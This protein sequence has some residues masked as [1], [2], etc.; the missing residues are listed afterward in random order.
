MPAFLQFKPAEPM[1]Q[2]KCAKCQEEEEGQTVQHKCA[3]C[4]QAEE[5]QVQHKQP[6]ASAPG[7]IHTAAAGV[8]GACQPLPH[9]SRIQASFGHH[10][11]TGARAAVG[12]QAAQANARSGSLA[13]TIGDRIAFRRPPDV[14]LAAHE[15]AHVVQQRNGAKLP[16]GVGKPGDEYEQQAD[17]V[18]EAVSRGESAEPILDRSLSGPGASEPVVQHA[19]T[20]SAIHVTEPPMIAT[21]VALGAG[22]A[23][24]AAGGGRR[25]EGGAPAQAAQTGQS[26]IAQA[27]Q[28]GGP[29]A[30]AQPAAPASAG[31]TPAQTDGGGSVNAHCYN[32]DFDEPSEDSDEE[33]QDPPVQK[34]RDEVHP[35]LPRPDETDNCPV[36]AAVNA[37]APAAAGG[38]GAQPA[39]PSAPGAPG[40]PGAGAAPAAPALAP[41]PPAAAGGG[42][43]T[44]ATS[45]G[46][47]GAATAA[48]AG[49]AAAGEQAAQGAGPASPS[50]GKDVKAG[51]E[52]A[53]AAPSPLEEAIT[54]SES[55]RDAAVAAFQTSDASTRELAPRIAALST[56]VHFLP[57]PAADPENTRAAESRLGDFFKSASD[58]LGEGLALAT[59]SVPERLGA[60]AEGIKSAIGST[61][62]QQKSILSANVE[63]ART[64]A[65]AAAGSARAVVS[66]EHA[67]T[68][69]LINAQ[70][71]AAIDALYDAYGESMGAIDEIES[72]SLDEVNGLYSASY[73][74]HVALGPDYAGRAEAR[75]EEYAAIYERCK[76]YNADGTPWKDSFMAGYLTNRRAEAQVKAAR[77]TA[78]GYR[79]SL[80]QA[81]N[82]QAAQ[83]MKGRRKDRCGIIAAGRRTRTSIDDRL[84]TLIGALESG[85]TDAIA[86]AGSTRSSMLASISSGLSNA[87][88]ALDLLEHDGRQSLDDTA[89]LQQLAVE[90]AAHASVTAVQ[91]SVSKAVNSV[92]GALVNL[93]GML[94]ESPAPAPADVD[95]VLAQAAAGLNGGIDTLLATIDSSVASATAQLDQAGEGAFAAIDSDA[96]T[97]LDRVRT[98]SDSFSSQV[99]SVAAGAAATFA[100]SRDHYTEQAQQTADSG[101]QGFMQAAAGFQQACD[102]MLN[103]IDA[104]LTRSEDNLAKEFQKQI[105]GLDSE[106]TGIPHQANEAASKEQPAWKGI[107]A[108]IL[109]IAIIIVVALVIGP[110]V[111]G[112]VGAAAAALGASAGVATAVGAIVGGAIVGALSSGAITVVQNWASGQSLTH[113][114]VRA[115]AVGALTGA[116]GGAI[117]LG[118]NA[119]LN[120]V[121]QGG[122]A[123]LSAGAQFAIRAA[124]NVTSDALQNI[125][126]QLIMTGHVDWSEFAQGVAMSL[127]L[128]GSRRVQAFQARVT[129]V[130]ARGAARGIGAFGGAEPSPAAARASRFAGTMEHHAAVARE[131]AARPL[132]WTRPTR[133]AEAPAATPPAETQPGAPPREAAPAAPPSEAAPAAPPR[134]VAPAAPRE[135]APPT[136][137]RETTPAAAPRETAPPEAAAAPVTDEHPSPGAVHESTE[138]TTARAAAADPNAV[139]TIGSEPQSGTRVGVGEHEVYIRRGPRGVEVGMCSGVCGPLRARIEEFQARIRES[140]P[141]HQALEDLKARTTDLEQRVERGE[142]TR[143]QLER[144]MNDIA[145]RVRLAA[146]ENPVLRQAMEA[147]APDEAAALAREKD[148][149]ETHA[150]LTGEPARTA[151]RPGFLD[152][153]V[154]DIESKTTMGLRRGESRLIAGRSEVPESVKQW[155]RAA[156]REIHGEATARAIENVGEHT[157]LT[158]ATVENLENLGVEFVE[159]VAE[160]RRLPPEIDFSHDLTVADFPEFAHMGEEVGHGAIH[161]RHMGEIHAGE[162]SAPLELAAPRSQPTQE[163]FGL[164]V[165]Y[166]PAH[167]GS[168]RESVRGVMRETRD[169]AVRLDRQA[170]TLTRRA[171]ALERAARGEARNLRNDAAA[172]T[173]PAEAQ[174]LTQRAARIEQRGQDLAAQLRQRA[175]TKNQRAQGLRAA[176]P[177]LQAAIEG[178]TP[179]K[180]R[181]LGRV[182]Q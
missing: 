127:V 54:A 78:S 35:D 82:D 76:R 17:T 83:A 5:E 101:A 162:P 81:A 112:A 171:A 94:A 109:I 1:V 46:P 59:D 147:E 122:R 110:A 106:A 169:L 20:V 85:R 10:D 151:R 62:E 164:H 139:P 16:G 52:A 49:P 150:E 56:D 115:M 12:G 133:A 96:Q 157:P 126:Q 129:A 48:P 19:L 178:G 143:N 159:A 75:G 170:D 135:A 132:D 117:G 125:G 155:A 167:G 7:S 39:A 123:A 176:L 88:A 63:A 158:Q 154:H 182:V 61:M 95:R 50:A 160:S 37:Q 60:T 30:P 9:L 8:A 68:V 92:E 89:Y 11:V 18:A 136:P 128:H 87:L 137:P 36:E 79:D 23:A 25:A 166:D 142:V 152:E 65:H 180:R 13:Y 120:A 168:L 175:T 40:A 156:A 103:G 116:V 181:D 130:G 148:I 99:D 93:R 113:G 108:V 74:A 131:E 34:P 67:S 4:E 24:T 42:A 45:A 145:A 53:A 43:P 73:D 31:G 21:H 111:I 15:A 161:T 86:Q 41:T 77:T 55:G 102:T 172:A 144:E 177:E 47:P 173:T 27:D 138:S 165:E 174:R 33:P 38:G 57:D 91:D 69:A 2:H 105:G 44:P 66:A 51:A 179:E 119:G 14:K 98:Q 107:V 100:A 134:E 71:D 28:G 90:Q 26:A 140:D 29:A 84:T 3:A 97:S 104:T 153:S 6:G 72:G 22:G 32:A 124:V 118:V 141:T 149:R 70:T 163:Q 146:D 64:E 121:L 58:R 80:V 114:L